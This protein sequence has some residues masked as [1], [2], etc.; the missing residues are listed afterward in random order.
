MPL[1]YLRLAVAGLVRTPLR[2]ALTCL[3]VG[4]AVCL[5]LGA[6]GLHDGYARAL[7]RSVDRMGYHVL[8]TAKGCPYETATLVLRGGDIPMYVD[9]SLVETLKADPA[10]DRGTRFLMQAVERVEDR[11]FTVFLGI[12]DEFR[13]LKPW[14]S[15]QQGAWF[16]SS[17]AAEVILGYNVAETLRKAPGDTLTLHDYGLSLAVGGVFDRS[18]S[19]D[20]GMIFLPLLSA[21]KLFNRQGKLTGVGV[22]LTDLDGMGP[23]LDRAFETPSL[24]AITVAQFRGTML[25]LL[26]TARALMLLGTAVAVVIAALGVFNAVLVSVTERKEELGVMK[27]LGASP[28]QVL[29]VVTAET[30]VVGV[31]GGAIGALLAWGA[32]LVSDDF[33]ARLLPFAPPPAEG[34]LIAISLTHAAV[35]IAGALA[36]ALAAGLPPAVRACLLPAARSLRDAR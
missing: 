17:D 13:A 23:F 8:V 15:L 34:H 32:G 1:R 28:L 4:L 30:A 31:A 27:V 29:A 2:F 24:Q 12:D 14:M 19:Q 35:G 18:G 26:S 5:F 9:E 22:R 11:G 6:L 3:A 25:D 10:W 21:Q 36:V 16:S 33:V 20:D 7:A